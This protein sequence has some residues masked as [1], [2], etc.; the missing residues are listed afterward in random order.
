MEIP[1]RGTEPAA[2]SASGERRHHTGAGRFRNI[3]DAR[4]VG[5][6]A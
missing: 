5:R 1:Y 4:P 2:I 6:P 3:A